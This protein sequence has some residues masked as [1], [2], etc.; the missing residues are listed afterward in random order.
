MSMLF[1]SDTVGS[2]SMKYLFSRFACG[3]RNISHFPM[4]NISSLREQ[5]YRVAFRKHID[6]AEV[7]GLWLLI[8][9]KGFEVWRIWYAVSLWLRLFCLTKREISA[10]KVCFYLFVG[11]TDRRGRR[12]LHILYAVCAKLCLVAFCQWY[13]V[14]FSMKFFIRGQGCSYTDARTDRF[15]DNIRDYEN[16]YGTQRGS[17]RQKWQKGVW[18]FVG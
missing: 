5:T 7:W 4:A 1:V 10:F 17:L 8:R 2:F 15:S 12:S 9:E 14:S 18:F 16:R 13:G 11:Q 6:L 3:G